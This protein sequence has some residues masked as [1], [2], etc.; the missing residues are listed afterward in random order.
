MAKSDTPFVILG[1][2]K[3][4]GDAAQTLGSMPLRWP[5]SATVRAVRLAR[6]ST[7]LKQSSSTSPAGAPLPRAGRG[8]GGSTA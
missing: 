8:G 7:N 5:R 6:T 4:R 1:R 3:E 2:S